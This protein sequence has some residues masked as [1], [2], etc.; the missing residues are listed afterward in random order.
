MVDA[1]RGEGERRLDER[2]ALTLLAAAMFAEAR[3]LPAGDE[4][5]R[6]LAGYS[7]ILMH[8]RTAGG[9]REPRYAIRAVSDGPVLRRLATLMDA[10]AFALEN[11]SP[12]ARQLSNW[13]ARITTAVIE[14]DRRERSLDGPPDELVAMVERMRRDL[15]SDVAAQADDLLAEG[16]A[17]TAPPPAERPARPRS[18]PR[19]PRPLLRRTGRVW[20]RKR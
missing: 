19:P 4:L 9:A 15:G 2:R 16:G 10:L 13:S 18:E 7:V 11:A 3:E 12:V 1:G 8:G 20:S 6:R 14:A 17:P 5:R